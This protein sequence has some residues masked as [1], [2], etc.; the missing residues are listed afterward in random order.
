MFGNNYIEHFINFFFKMFIFISPYNIILIVLIVAFFI[1]FF[2][3]IIRDSKVDSP[4]SSEDD[5]NSV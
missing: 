3:V 5:V 1:F 4:N 2:Y